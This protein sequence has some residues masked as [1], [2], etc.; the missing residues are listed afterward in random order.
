MVAI[1]KCP[2]CE[3]GHMK[4]IKLSIVGDKRLK[5]ILEQTKDNYKNG[6]FINRPVC[7]RCGYVGGVDGT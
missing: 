7:S 1:V 5:L 4:P 3:K 6:A 2:K